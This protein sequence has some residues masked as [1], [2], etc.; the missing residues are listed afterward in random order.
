M[1]ASGPAHKSSVRNTRILNQDSKKKWNNTSDMEEAHLKCKNKFFIE[2][3]QDYTKFME[4]TAL[5]PSFDWNTE[6]KNKTHFYSRNYEN[7]IRKW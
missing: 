5:P 1:T 3:Q 2:F 4:V 7:I 6:N